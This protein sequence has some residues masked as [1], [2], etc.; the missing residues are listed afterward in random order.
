MRLLFE[1]LLRFAFLNTNGG[2]GITQSRKIPRLVIRLIQQHVG[3]TVHS[4]NA[5]NEFSRGS[6]VE[7]NCFDANMPIL[8]IYW[9][10]VRI[11]R[12]NE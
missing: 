9:I 8:W 2:D 4:N 5:K 11:I 7:K 1:Y 10:V 6:N 12:F 3:Y